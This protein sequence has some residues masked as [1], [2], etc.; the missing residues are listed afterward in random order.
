[1][2]DAS[3]AFSLDIREVAHGSPDYNALVVLR[4][5]VLRRPLGRTFTRAEL[6][7]ESGSV[8]VGAWE[9]DALAGCLVLL[10]LGKGRVQMRQVAVQKDRQG[11]GVGRALVDFAETW[12]RGQK[13]EVMVL[14]ARESAVGFYK[15]L[16]YRA[17]GARFEEVGLPH[18]EMTKAL[19]RNS[20]ADQSVH[21]R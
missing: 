19:G 17:Q 5:D 9:G 2:P 1:M 3:T 12:A 18:R 20:F 14:H 15:T 21:A 11:R 10:P 8:H 6:D 4:H 7:A 13:F 16:G